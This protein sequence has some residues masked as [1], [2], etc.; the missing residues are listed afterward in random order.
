MG[1]VETLVSSKTALNE[2]LL[3]VSWRAY[4]LERRV[5]LWTESRR[6][7]NVTHSWLNRHSQAYSSKPYLLLP[8]HLV[9]PQQT[10]RHRLVQILLNF[11]LTDECHRIYL[12]LP[13][14]NF[15]KSYLAYL[16]SAF[17]VLMNRSRTSRH[18]T[19]SSFFHLLSSQKL[20]AG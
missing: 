10:C 18:V 1:L 11:Q 12:L 19:W 3:A 2:F 20:K 9:Y 5:M 7:G 13:D 8:G 4:R 17:S 16:P 15:A 14:R 6:V